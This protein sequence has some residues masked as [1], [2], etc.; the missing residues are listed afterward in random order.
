MSMNVG[1]IVTL[2]LPPF[3]LETV[4]NRWGVNL[5]QGLTRLALQGFRRAGML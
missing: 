3:S 1:M 5:L 2:V 4:E